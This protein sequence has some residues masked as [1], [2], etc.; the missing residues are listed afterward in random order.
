MRSISAAAR[1]FRASF[2]PCLFLAAGAV[3]AGAEPRFYPDDPLWEDLDRVD[4]PCPAEV[5]L[6]DLYD[7]VYHTFIDPGNKTF[8]EALNINTL[9]QVP[10]SSWFTN[11]HGRTPMTIEQLVRGPNTVDGPDLTGELTIVASK[12]EGVQ[13]GF[14]IEDQRGDR[15]VIKFDRLE[16]PELNSAAEML[17]TK[18]MYAIGYN[19]PENFIVEMDPDQLR[20]KEGTTFTDSYGDEIPLNAKRLERM[21]NRVDRLPNGRVRAL[22]SKYVPGRPIGPFRYSGTRR[23]DPNDVIPHED[24]RE[25]RALRVF[26]AWINH[27]DARAQNTLDAYVEMDGR[28][29]VEHYLI[30]FGSSFGAGKLDLLI[31]NTGFDYWLEPSNVGKQ[32]AG[33]GFVVP[34]YRQVDWPKLDPAVGRYEA[35]AFDAA[36]WVPD[37]PNPAF[38]RA[39][40]RDL[41]WAA[42][43]V[44]RFTE[45]ELRA[46]VH[47]AQFSDPKSEATMLEVLRKRQQKVGSEFIR[48]INPLDEFQVDGNMLRWAN[49]AEKY[50]LA[51][52]PSTYRA[53]WSRYDNVTNTE[54]AIA[55]IASYS[56]PAAG[57]AVGYIGPSML[58]EPAV[59][60]PANSLSAGDFLQCE[61]ATLNEA[62]PAWEMPVVVHLRQ[63]GGSLEVVGVSR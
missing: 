15:Y 43:I 42:A 35:D 22:A 20:I 24:R 50:A 38:V 1:A 11:R 59:P 9:D 57:G 4:T 45:E 60:I 10:N 31:P 5:K 7:R 13:P 62:H 46:I 14:Q 18:L 37:Y 47:T 53:T 41:F 26:S 3:I 19:V 30:D 61:I 2:L 6:S 54:T 36:E 12:N 25:L 16:Y 29:Y 55:T 33:L 58:N 51:T 21:L 8:G 23:D 32:L 17:G 44:M 28:H 56:G 52:A 40:D 27:D 34:R 48:R 49:L 39:T 63:K